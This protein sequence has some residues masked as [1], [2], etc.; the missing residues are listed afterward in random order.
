MK[1]STL[2]RRKRKRAQ[3]AFQHSLM[4]FALNSIHE[5][6]F[7]IDEKA[8]FQ[9]VNEM[10]CHLVGYPRDELLT[11]SISDI[12]HGFHT[13]PWPRCWHDIKEQGAFTFEREFK[14][15]DG[16]LFPV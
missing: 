12:S 4:S 7:L 16:R 1:P 10:A 5:A 3:E 2:I 14:A 15:G 11:M 9:Y 8:C 6:V 13:E